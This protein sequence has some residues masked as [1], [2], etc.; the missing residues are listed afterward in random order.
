MTLQQH[1]LKDFWID[2][3]RETILI[4]R[5]DL[6]ISEQTLRFQIMKV[7]LAVELAYYDVIAARETVGVEE[8]ALELRRQL[9]TETRRRVEVGDLPPLDSEQAETQL[10]NVLTALTAAREALGERQNALK[11]LLTDNFGAWAD[12]ELRATDALIANESKIDRSDS[13]A[14]ALKNRPD[15]IEA[16]LAVEKSAV[17]VRFRFNQLFP[18]L[19]LMAHYGGLGIQ[20]D[21]SSALSDALH[22][23]QQEYFYGMVLTFPLD[24]IKERNDYRSSKAAR[25]IAELQ[26]KKAEQSV[27]VEVADL[28]NRVQS[29]FSQVG[30]T[31]K[32]RLYAESALAAEQKKLQNGISTSFIVLQ[33]QEILTVARMA[34]LQALTD[35]NKVVA[36][37]AFAEGNNLE[38]HRM[39]IEIK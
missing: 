5:R 4:K 29:R 22:F 31:H 36:Q 35:Y 10:Q 18:S 2:Q 1:L 33:L 9:L 7:V 3:D 32:A 17:V 12:S 14:S 25:Q 16:R 11:N 28:V 20:P 38:R 27:L 19:D 6:K 26:L 39:A 15:L 24:N 30:S 37:L 34:E 8:K 23:R 13:F 21:G